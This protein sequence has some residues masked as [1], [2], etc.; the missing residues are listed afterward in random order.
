MEMSVRDADRIVLGH[1]ATITPPPG[2]TKLIL[3][4]AGEAN[5]RQALAAAGTYGT[6]TR[7][8]DGTFVGAPGPAP[9][10]PEDI[11]L[12]RRYHANPTPT[13][14][15]SVAAIKAIIRVLRA[16]QT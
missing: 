16:L 9:P 6:V 8:L 2:A 12:L 13:A 10:L 11:L 5:Y 15:D 1:G 14:A 3:D 4:D 7:N